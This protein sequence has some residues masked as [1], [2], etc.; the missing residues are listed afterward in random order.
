M[1]ASDKRIPDGSTRNATYITAEWT[2]P[3]RVVVKELNGR[4][5][6]YMP[7]GDEVADVA[8][9]AAVAP[10]EIINATADPIL[11]VHTNIY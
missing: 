8:V 11:P 2:L 6:E 4:L 5:V 1:I 9:V 10:D 3:G 7:P